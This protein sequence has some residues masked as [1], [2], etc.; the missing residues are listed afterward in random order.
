MTEKCKGC[1]YWYNNRCALTTCPRVD[2]T[3]LDDP[4]IPEILK[5]SKIKVNKVK[6][7]KE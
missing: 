2:R 3:W 6:G 5:T 7:D 4:K 1:I